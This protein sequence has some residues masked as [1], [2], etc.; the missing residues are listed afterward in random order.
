[1]T[2]PIKY[3]YI[4]LASNQPG[5]RLDVRVIDKYP[6]TGVTRFGIALHG[7]ATYND[8][9]VDRIFATCNGSTISETTSRRARPDVQRALGLATDQVGF[10][11][12]LNRLLIP[13]G[14]T[15]EICCELTARE[16]QIPA[17]MAAISI[18]APIIIDMVEIGPSSNYNSSPGH[19]AIAGN[20]QVVPLRKWLLSQAPE[21]KLSVLEQYHHINEQT[22]IDNWKQDASRAE[23]TYYIPVRSDYRSLDFDFSA[24][25]N[26]RTYVNFYSK[27]LYPFYGYLEDRQYLNPFYG[28]YHD[29]IAICLA[30]GSQLRASK[31]FKAILASG[32]N[33]GSY[34][35]TQNALDS[36]IETRKR[37]PH[38]ATISELN[39]ELL[40]GLTFDHPSI[41]F[42]NAYYFSL[43]CHELKCDP[44]L[45]KPLAKV[46]FPNTI[47]P[48]SNFVIRSLN[49]DRPAGYWQCIKPEL[50]NNVISDKEYIDILEEQ[51]QWYSKYCSDGCER[52]ASTLHPIFLKAQDFISASI[53][54]Y[55]H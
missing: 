8:E 20:C 36:C 49:S 35:I 34:I 6:Y 5:L 19:L 12:I 16:V 26:L 2:K 41:D 38:M 15:V 51:I 3:G 11:L 29:F 9:P 25:P 45:F 17:L 48:I 24:I 31:F 32:G 39:P 44:L 37:H 10:V 42:L 14:G 47:L 27:L 43:W 33:A 30:Y 13:R 1:M 55:C 22:L 28:P 52:A 46:C 4:R 54:E 21:S 40:E 53:G 18:D 50:L 7:W 23:A